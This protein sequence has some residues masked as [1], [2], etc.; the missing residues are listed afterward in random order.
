MDV[1]D[2]IMRMLLKKII[3]FS[4]D[5]ILELTRQF[6][7]SLFDYEGDGTLKLTMSAIKIK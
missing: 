3:D 5:L 4:N 1:S 7:C 2:H 6:Y